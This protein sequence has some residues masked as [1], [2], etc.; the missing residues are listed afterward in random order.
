MLKK[1]YPLL[2]MLAPL[3]YVFAVILG[4][5][6]MPE[7]THIYN[8]ISELTGAGFPDFLILDILFIFYNL[9]LMAFALGGLLFFQSGNPRLARTLFTLLLAAG[10]IGLLLSFFPQDMRGSAPTFA[11]KTHIILAAIISPATVASALI[12]GFAF[13]SD[14]VYQRLSGFS[15]VMALVILATGGAT[16]VSIA[17]DSPI[18][19]VFERLTI[20]AFLLWLYVLAARINSHNYQ[21][22]I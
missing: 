12:A 4:G 17:S 16:A 1:W 9:L 3:V 14:P 5:F 11:G 10:L 22:A 15:F 18:G 21:K 2:G 20:G 19:G 13:R 8:T 6:I 7:Y